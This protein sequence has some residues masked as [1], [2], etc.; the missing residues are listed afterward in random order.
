MALWR[1]SPIAEA[2]DAWWQ[3]R[4]IWRE[5][6]VRADSAALARLAAAELEADP[7]E[8]LSGNES[9]SFK[10]GFLDEKLYRVDRTGDDEGEPA[11]LK[12][13]EGRPAELLE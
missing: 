2:D 10:S 7:A 5:V 6:I 13:A 9:P 3:G 8:P 4:R 1:L 12:A 11:V